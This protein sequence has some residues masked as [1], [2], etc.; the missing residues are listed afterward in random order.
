MEAGGWALGPRCYSDWGRAQKGSRFNSRV[1]RS[2]V[3]QRA[4]HLV[5][6]GLKHPAG[7][8]TASPRRFFQV[9]IK[10]PA[11][12]PMHIGR[13]H[14]WLRNVG[15]RPA[16]N[17]TPPGCRHGWRHTSGLG[18]MFGGTRILCFRYAAQAKPPAQVW[19]TTPS[20]G[21]RVQVKPHAGGE[22]PDPATVAPQ[23]RCCAGSQGAG[24]DGSGGCGAPPWSE[25]V[26]SGTPG[27]PGGA[28]LPANHG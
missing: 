7:P 16:S 17:P 5:S 23:G 26:L 10:C 1:F 9:Y 13:S 27:G 6:R 21:A 4:A 3:V 2:E 14:G 28:T 12:N 24:A 11:S 25:N 18:I 19:P 22:A 8:K 15:C 20:T